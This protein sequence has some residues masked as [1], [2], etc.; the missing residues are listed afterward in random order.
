[1]TQPQIKTVQCISPAGLHTMAYKEWGDPQNKK[2]LMCVHGV[3]RVSDD[4]DNMAQAFCDTYRVICPDIVGRGR[5]DWLKDPQHYQLPQYVNDIVTL[6]ARLDVESLDWFGTSMG[7]LIG[8]GLAS[9]PKHPIRKL[10]L[11][12]VGPGLNMTALDRIGGYIGEAVKFPTFEEAVAYIRSISAP[13]GPHTDEEW[14]K[15]AADVLV[16]GPDGLWTRH[17]DLGL[18]A[19]FKTMTPEIAKQSASILWYAYDAVSC[20][21]MLVRGQNSD[22]L[23]HEVAVEMT[24]RGPKV[25]LVEIPGV[26]H[27][28]TFMH[29]DQIAI[30]R[31]FFES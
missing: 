30:A 27:A 9:F 22:L 16:Q 18:A 14:R 24:K 26:G 11:N 4:F 7:G 15:L 1:M 28:P 10:I 13:F 29:A 2:V 25:K 31:E 19:P 20:P 17:Y 6:I 12:D 3:T 5:S 21:T 23:S 8:M